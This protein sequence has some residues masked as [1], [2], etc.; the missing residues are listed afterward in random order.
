M[1]EFICEKNLAKDIIKNTKPAIIYGG[2]SIIVWAS[3]SSA[4]VER[5]V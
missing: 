3:F 1:K 2:G 5:Y 4:G